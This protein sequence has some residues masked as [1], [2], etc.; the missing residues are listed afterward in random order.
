MGGLGTV[1]GDDLLL[2]MAQVVDDVGDG[3][4]V[5]AAVL[6]GGL[7]DGQGVVDLPLQR[8]LHHKLYAA[9]RLHT[10]TRRKAINVTIR[11]KIDRTRN[12][13]RWVEF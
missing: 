9:L 13:S 11:M 6:D 10:D 1:D 5:Q 8:V 3:A 7:P 4:G 2:R 12:I